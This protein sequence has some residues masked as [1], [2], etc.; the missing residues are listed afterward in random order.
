MTKFLQKL[1]FLPIEQL[2][3]DSSQPRTDYGVEGAH[4]QLSESLKEWGVQ[5]PLVVMDV[6]KTGRYLIIDGHRRY[7]CAKRIGL[8]ELPCIVCDKAYQ[9]K[10]DRFRYEIQ[11]N[12]RAW[13]PSERASA[14]ASIKRK[15]HFSSIEELAKAV[16]LPMET[17]GN[18]LILLEQNG[19]YLAL[20]ERNNLN[21][22]FQYQLTQLLPKIRRAGNLEVDEIIPI[23]IKKINNKVITNSREI[24]RLGSVFLRFSQNESAITEFLQKEAMTVRELA[25]KTLLTG[26]TLHV[27]SLIDSI[28]TR[29]NAGKILSSSETNSL[30]QLK[31]LLD[32]VI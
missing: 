6:D 22:T 30:N 27:E 9:Q 16:H 2:Q 26:F 15:G 4:N 1:L 13:R 11:N 10:L 12:R 23:I 19:R 20:W 25:H 29:L 8:K 18:S 3:M 14:L 28:S 17:V 7:L 32:Q 21:A 24:R 31:K 5:V